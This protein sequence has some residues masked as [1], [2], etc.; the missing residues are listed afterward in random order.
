M[1]FSNTP[2][3]SQLEST[4]YSGTCKKRHFPGNVPQTRKNLVHFS[5]RCDTLQGRKNPLRESHQKR[6]T[7]ETPPPY[8]RPGHRIIPAADRHLAPELV[9][10]ACAPGAA[11]CTLR[12]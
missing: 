4:H 3:H 10:P 12:A 11:F 1:D 5:M 6:E 2:L 7:H 9:P 8:H